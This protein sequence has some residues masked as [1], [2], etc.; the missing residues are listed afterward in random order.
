MSAAIRQPNYQGPFGNTLLH[1]AVVSRDVKEVERLLAAGAPI[2]GF[3][4]GSKMG[5]AADAAFLDMAYKLVELDGRPTLKLSAGKATLP[6]PKQVWRLDGRD[7][8]N[9]AAGRGEGE[10]LLVDAMRGGGRLHAEPLEESRARAREQREALPSE[11]HRVDAR[12]PE[13]GVSPELERLREELV[14]EVVS[15]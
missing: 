14:S 10:P 6:G 8:L 5:T 11:L 9:L 2:G 1:G 7:V 3:G 15:K 13:V 4:V 12:P